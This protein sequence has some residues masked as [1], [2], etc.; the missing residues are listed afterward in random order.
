M[1]SG[2]TGLLRLIARGIA[3][4]YPA[5]GA[6]ILVVDYRRGLLGAVPDGHLLGYA[7]SEPVL[8]PMLADVARALRTRLP[9]PDVTAEQ[10]R[11]RSWWSGPELFLVVDDYDLVAGQQGNPLAVLLDLLP[12]ARDIG[13]HLIL[14]RRSGGAGRSLYEPVVQ[15]IR[16]LGSPGLILS[17]SRDEGPL[18]GDEKPS[19]QPPGRGTLVGRRTGARLVQV[20]WLPPHGG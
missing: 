18:L 11:A 20:A 5:A 13:L 12:Q 19:P 3:D 17:G 1:E 16:E 4:R 10:L 15:R 8:T 7:G 6:G 2:K 14:A 9:G